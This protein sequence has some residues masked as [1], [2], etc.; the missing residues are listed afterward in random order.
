M[1]EV[2]TYSFTHQELLELMVKASDVHEGEWMLN[3]NFGFLAGNFGPNDN[4]VPGGVVGVHQIGIT[5]AKEGAP[6]SLVINAAK[7]NPKPST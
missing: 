2:E 5:K 1:P 3:I 4:I 6:K 7:V